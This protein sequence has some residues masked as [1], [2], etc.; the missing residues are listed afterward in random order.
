MSGE[1]S[2]ERYLFGVLDDLEAQ[3]GAA[4]A[5]ERAEEIEDRA[6][7][8]YVNVTLASRLMAEVG[9]ELT[10]TL[11][12]VG[13]VTGTLQRVATGWLLLDSA[14]AEWIVR[15]NVI[16]SARPVG[17]RAVPEVAWPVAARLRLPSAVRR[18]ADAASYCV[19]HQT[20]GGRHEGVPV[21][22]GQDF[23]EVS[24]GEPAQ[25]MLV[26]I[27]TLAAIQSR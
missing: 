2:W 6:R 13:P 8:E 20:D 11:A 7:A 21:R 22:V 16:T 4:F 26:P 27:P 24:Y 9:R 12:G 23:I 10:L 3:A 15:H 5:A 17:S 19:F 14:G 1:A 18:L 25:L